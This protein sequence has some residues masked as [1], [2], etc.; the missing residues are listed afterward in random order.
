MTQANGQIAL[1]SQKTNLSRRAALT[2]MAL[3]AA[4]T[5]VAA[6]CVAPGFEGPDADLF[7]AVRRYEA[8][9]KASRAIEGWPDDM[10]DEQ[11]TAVCDEQNAALAD[12]MAMT[13]QTVAGCAAVLRCVQMFGDQMACPLFEGWDNQIGERG[14]TLLGR[15][16]TAL[17]EARP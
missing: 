8:A 11:I 4:P 10:T 5:T 15:M 6:V 12:L 17:T 7:A 13:P 1:I 14:A 2:G 3:L 9:H 16:A